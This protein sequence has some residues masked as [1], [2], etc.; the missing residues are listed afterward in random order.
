MQKH[1]Y[2][3]GEQPILPYNSNFTNLPIHDP[4]KEFVL[5]LSHSDLHFNHV[6]VV[7]L[8]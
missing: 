8:I 2:F 7:L 5:M 3:A 4:M 6:L 1:L